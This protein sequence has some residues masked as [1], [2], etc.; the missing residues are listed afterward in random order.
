M[1]PTAR[2]TTSAFPTREPRQAAARARV[3][4]ERVD[5]SRWGSDC[6]SGRGR[7]GKLSGVE[8]DV[9]T[10]KLTRNA[11][12][13]DVVAP[14]KAPVDPASLVHGHLQSGPFWQKVPAYA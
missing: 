2:R 5:F 8:M 7:R 1:D 4:G 10:L 12:N 6:L 11:N 3:D 14:L 9:L 13:G